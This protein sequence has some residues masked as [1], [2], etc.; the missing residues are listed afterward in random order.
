MSYTVFEDKDTKYNLKIAAQEG[1]AS[2]ILSDDD[3]TTADDVV[4]IKA[5]EN[6]LNK[7]IENLQDIAVTEKAPKLEGKNM[8]IILSTKA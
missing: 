7:F 5:G 2:V 4:N 8:F 1:K 6:V 3:E